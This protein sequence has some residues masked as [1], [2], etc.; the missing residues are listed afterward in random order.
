MLKYYINKIKIDCDK[1]IISLI[2][3][4]KKIRI[5]TLSYPYLT[6]VSFT[7]VWKLRIA[8]KFVSRFCSNTKGRRNSTV[9]S[10]EQVNTIG[11]IISIRA[12]ICSSLRSALIKLPNYFLDE[13]SRCI[14]KVESPTERIRRKARRSF[15]FAVCAHARNC[16]VKA[17]LYGSFSAQYEMNVLGER[18]FI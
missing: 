8:V 5:V 16:M 7:N 13:A 1:T 4:A 14:S 18:A 15:H 2:K 12:S 9:F 10:C 6:I 17:N 11:L 3:I